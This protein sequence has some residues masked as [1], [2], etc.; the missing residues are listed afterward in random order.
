L[1]NAKFSK[2]FFNMLIINNIDFL[3]NSKVFQKEN[4]MYYFVEPLSQ[5]AISWTNL[6]CD[7]L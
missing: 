1:I 7:L 3:L 5:C 6:L 2:I 4:C